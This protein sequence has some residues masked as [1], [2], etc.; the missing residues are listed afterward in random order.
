MF[1]ETGVLYTA[2][3][4]DLIRRDSP[5][6]PGE[7]CKSQTRRLMNP[8]PVLEGGEWVWR[9]KAG[10]VV[11][12]TAAR[13]HCPTGN[14]SL[15]IDY[16][17]WGGPSDLL[18]LKE[19]HWEWGYWR[20]EGRLTASGKPKRRFMGCGLITFEM[21]STHVEIS[22]PSGAGGWY[23]RSPLFMPKWAARDWRELTGVRIERVNLITPADAILEGV[24][25]VEEYQQE[26]DDINPKAPFANGPWVWVYDF[27]EV[28]H[29][30]V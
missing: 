6:R 24:A 12:W 3:N 4:R 23:F 2:F 16:A 17:P 7:K 14:L 28:R 13:P 21:P 19:P 25:T 20:T 15:A 30:A 9:P 10:V 18:Y 29:G 8:Q 26:W 27:K 5:T 1:R 22:A 11:T